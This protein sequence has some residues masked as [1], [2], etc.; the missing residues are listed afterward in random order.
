MKIKEDSAL[1]LVKDLLWPYRK[2]S[3]QD[4]AQSKSDK[5]V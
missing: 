3:I 4:K 1:Q 2:K 5:S